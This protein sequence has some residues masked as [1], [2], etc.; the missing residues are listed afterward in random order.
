MGDIRVRRLFLTAS[1][2]LLAHGAAQGARPAPDDGLQAG[3]AVRDIT[4]RPDML[5]MERPPKVQITGFHDP[6]HVRVIALA[7]GGRKALIVSTETG[8]GPYA[9]Q[10]IAALSRHT[11]IPADS[12]FYTATH[13]HAVPEITAPV[14]LAHRTDG[15]ETHTERW[16][17]MVMANMLDAA[18]VA[19]RSLRPATICIGYGQSFINVNRLTDYRR[20]DAQ[21]NWVPARNLGFNPTGVS[22]KTLAAIR[23]SGEDGKPIAMIIHH[24]LH[25]TV[26]HANTL[27]HGKT[28][29]SA[30]VPGVVSSALE[31]EYPGAV[32]MWLSG[33]AGDQNP[34][35]QNDFY[36]RDPQTGEFV[37]HFAGDAYLLDY[38]G[39]IQARDAQQA[40]A[41][42]RPVE[43][44]PEL[45]VDY[46]RSA[47]PGSNGGDYRVNLRMLRVG[48]IALMGFSGELFTQLGLDIKKASRLPDTLV[49][50]HVWGEVGEMT[51]YHADDAA[52]ALGGF[53][54]DGR[55][56]PGH[57]AQALS[58]MAQTML[59]ESEMWELAG[60]GVAV[61]R[62]DG[63]VVLTGPDGRPG[64][65]DD[66]AIVN[67]AGKVLRRGVTTF[68][69][70]QGRHYV[71]LGR[72]LRLY[73]GEDGRLGTGD[74]VVRGFGRYRQEAGGEMEPLDWR[75]LDMSGDRLTLIAAAIVDAVPFDPAD[76]SNGWESSNLR[77]WLNSRGGRDAK[78]DRRGFLRLAFDARE[79]AMMVPNEMPASAQG[80]IAF[81]KLDAA[82]PWGRQTTPS[83]AP[84]D[85]V[86]VLSGEEL[87]RY[88]GPSRI[89]TQREL[90]HDPANYTNAYFRPTRWGI[91][92]GLKANIG[93]NGASF[94]GY[95]DA[96][97]RSP[98]AQASDGHAYGTFLG[99]TGSLNIGRSV[100]SPYGA[101]P[102][103][104]VKIGR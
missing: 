68:K 36:W 45:A 46:I 38:L 42:V 57:I 83:P 23:I 33:A 61:H 16:G 13:S 54:T 71:A 34:I 26:M 63:H 19:L 81:N 84:R 51:G 96:W 70:A 22:D 48:P 86:T 104:S 10:F 25:G 9:P 31:R 18:G 1:A 24:A 87:F 72:G 35:V 12:I 69:D 103:I 76:R 85:L 62:G 21:G 95:G 101:L 28:A 52:K 65:Q 49:V 27:D 55:Y 44:R 82:Q 6:V 39:A 2:I 93:H 17:Q 43:G 94:V 90:G 7:Q 92:Q 8:K 53:G 47:I 50:N 79:R 91:A 3:A 74:D 80:F 89:A 15:S 32:A 59:A 4:P 14:N 40:L 5:P 30:D 75:I 97:T 29:I 64:T 73:A 41:A 77:N 37:E 58:G 78:G 99:S 98:G 56:Q 11:G 88:F 67:P 102:V 66:D 60:D 20:K 100:A